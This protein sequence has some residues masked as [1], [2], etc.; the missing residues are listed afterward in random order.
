MMFSVYAQYMLR[1]TMSIFKLTTSIIF[2]PTLT[3]RLYEDPKTS[4]LEFGNV[5][6]PLGS[7]FKKKS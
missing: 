7:I 5:N 1:Q 3:Q 6:M 2:V 4:P